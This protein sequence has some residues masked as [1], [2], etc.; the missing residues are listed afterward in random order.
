MKRSRV[1]NTTPGWR[2]AALG[3]Q[4]SN[5]RPEPPPDLL[6]LGRITPKLAL[7]FGQKNLAMVLRVDFKGWNQLMGVGSIVLRGQL[8]PWAIIVACELTQCV[9]VCIADKPSTPIRAK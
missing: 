9:E 1:V 5:E 2:R 3:H 7:P 6:I 8:I 4:L